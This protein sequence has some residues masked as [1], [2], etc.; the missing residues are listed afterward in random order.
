MAGQIL[1][2]GWDGCIWMSAL[3]SPAVVI[4]ALKGKL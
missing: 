1:G 2:R 4:L 3:P